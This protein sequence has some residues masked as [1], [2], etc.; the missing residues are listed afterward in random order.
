MVLCLD[1]GVDNPLRHPRAHYPIVPREK[2]LHHRK[3]KLIFLF[4]AVPLL[5]S[6]LCPT[7]THAANPIAVQILRQGQPVN[8]KIKQKNG[9]FEVAPKAK[10]FFVQILVQL[11]PD[12][13]VQE[14]NGPD[15][16]FKPAWIRGDKLMLAVGRLHTDLLV[17]MGD[18]REENWRIDLSMPET[19]T[20]LKGCK[21]LGLKITTQNPKIPVFFA[22]ECSVRDQRIVFNPS[23]P[24]ELE[25]DVTSIFETDG[26]GERWKIF[27]MSRNTMVAGNDV[28]AQLEFNYEGAKTRFTLMQ[29]RTKATPDKP[30][31][32]AKD[33]WRTQAG[34]GFSQIKAKTPLASAASSH[35]GFMAAAISPTFFWKLRGEAELL[36]GLPLSQGSFYQFA[37]GLGPTFGAFAPGSST[38]AMFAEYFGLQQSGDDEGKAITFQHSTIGFSVLWSL[39]M[40]S[41]ELRA[42]LRYHGLGGDASGFEASLGYE[43]GTQ[44]KWGGLLKFGNQTAKSETGSSNFSQTTAGATLSF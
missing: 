25:W 41:S 32:V 38:F 11:P 29:N 10:A 16:L 4:F 34:L 30:D 18:G 12:I 27:E 26:K 36:Y 31:P 17:K 21:E 19:V 33:Q 40:Q 28:L 1:L 15:I 37:A 6:L 14:V 9:F 7:Q 43:I 23:V 2:R 24:S 8:W 35:P 5:A 44:R 22:A 39:N 3:M 13:K 42:W 20:Q